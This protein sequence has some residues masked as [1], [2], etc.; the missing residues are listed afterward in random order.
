MA[1]LKQHSKRVIGGF[2]QKLIEKFM[3]K[4]VM[5]GMSG[6]VDSSVTA[7]LLKQK[8]YDV[9][10][11]TLKLKPE[12]YLN[13]TYQNEN[14]LNKD[15]VDAKIVADKLGIKHMVADFTDLFE[16]KV[17][18]NFVNEYCNGRTPN[19]CVV[20]NKFLKFGAMF[21]Y[22]M[23][24]GFDYIATGHYAIVEFD[25]TKNKW[26]LKRANS[27]KDQSYVLYNLTQNH[28]A[29]TLFPLGNLE[30]TQTREIA[31]V[32]GLP[33]A[34]KPDSQ[35]ICFIKNENYVEF[36]KNHFNFISKKGSFVDKSGNILG[37]HSGILNYTI[38]QR[39]GLGVT[40]GK[41]MYVVGINAADNT[42]ILGEEGE[43][44]SNELIATNINFIPFDSIP[45]E[46][47][48]TAKIRYQAKPEKAR[49]IQLSH[50]KI[51]VTFERQQR[52]V[53]PGQSVVFYDGNTV[54]GGGII[55]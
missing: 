24:H 34:Q 5:V 43:Q 53:T 47:E 8:G 31:E 22:A 18:E 46:I 35:E 38:G 10:G 50:D 39:K 33:I 30:K 26:L 29:H 2:K 48:V 12:K 27:S 25:A 16:K 42:V 40:F 15:I 17:I 4:T 11:V 19:P 51:K 20:C 14:N 37:Q 23:E 3:S 45:G 49:L 52:S 7:L 54:L 21:D 36:I 9:T 44:Y 55:A 1:R 28:L 13:Q 6:G 41:P 32:F